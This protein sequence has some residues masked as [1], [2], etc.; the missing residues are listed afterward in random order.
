M[1]S[2]RIAAARRHLVETIVPPL[3]PY[4]QFKELPHLSLEIFPLAADEMARHV[5]ECLA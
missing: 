2:T 3:P 4:V 5:E 1:G